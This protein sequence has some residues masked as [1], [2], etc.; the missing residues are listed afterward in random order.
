MDELGS[1]RFGLGDSFSGKSNDIVKSIKL[2]SYRRAIANFVK[3]LTNKE[4]PVTFLGNTSYTDGKS[5]VIS[6]DIKDN[7]FDV[8]V[9]L[10]LHEASH[11]LLT[12]FDILPALRTRTDVNTA[13]TKLAGAFGLSVSEALDFI[14][15]MLNWVEDRRIDN[16]VFSTSP[17]YKAYYHKLYDYYWVSDATITK[18]L[19]S[20]EYTKH[21]ELN[22]WEMQI[23][24]MMNPAFDSSVMT[25]LTE[26][27]QVI[28]LAKI[29]RLKST[30][31]ALQVVLKMVE[32]IAEQS[33]L[34]PDQDGDSGED[35]QEQND[36]QG[37]GGQGNQ[38]GDEE[39]E[40]DGEEDEEGEGD[41]DSDLTDSEI[42]AVQN[43][44]KKQ[45]DF[46]EGRTG[47]KQASR[48][49]QKK[50]E[51]AEKQQVEYEM[52]DEGKTPCLNYDI[53][54]KE[55]I[56]AIVANDQID[57]LRSEVRNEPYSSPRR[58]EAN[59]QIESL[60]SL[61][62]L[63]DGNYFNGRYSKYDDAVDKGFLMGQ[64][65][66]KKLQ[67]RNEARERVDNRLRS[68]KIDNKRLAAAGYGIESIFHQVTIDKYKKANIHLSL[69]GS[70][71]MSGTKW[72]N[73]VKLA[74]AIAKGITYTQNVSMQISVRVSSN[75]G[76]QVLP[77]NYFIYDSRKNTLR[78]LEIVLKNMQPNGLTPEGLCFES[79][80]KKNQLIKTTS[81]MD[82]YFIN[83]SD[84]QPC[85]VSNYSGERAYRH[86]RA[87]VT[88]MQNEL[89]ISVLSYF[90]TGYEV[91]QE[92]F[93]DTSDGRAF[94][95]MYGKSATA[96]SA[97]NALDVAKTI[98]KLFMTK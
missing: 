86:T 30:E 4:I 78:E 51:I 97:D 14:K 57:K 70:G 62:E 24:N 10:A 34:K 35:Q 39:S 13:V 74:A 98:N 63:I 79:M 20:R 96:V 76:N 49:L 84:G 89:G 91:S 58:Q 92:R 42:R 11:I 61:T 69:D 6:T 44:L 22:S 71:S 95:Q 9:G 55:F 93:T 25:G 3:I 5:V 68:G 26:V 50:L 17:G 85:G 7:N 56:A 41:D 82:S 31:D 94:V 36:P 66:G 67:L 87:Q 77:S 23:I 81:E 60:R 72:E 37:Q 80:I 38:G 2:N 88:R 12:D 48:G 33:T 45:K 54:G 73:T 46:L 47:K 90:M 83:I 8:S 28:D 21:N 1:D 32:I 43:A 59:K 53:T 18:A 27:A 52:T 29:N 64:L 75:A 65:L 15:N 19:A 16:F 40:E